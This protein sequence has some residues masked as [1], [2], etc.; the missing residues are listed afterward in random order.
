MAARFEEGAFT[1]RECGGCPALVA[2]GVNCTAAGAAE[3]SRCKGPPQLIQS[4]GRIRGFSVREGFSAYPLGYRHGVCGGAILMF[5]RGPKVVTCWDRFVLLLPSYPVPQGVARLGR[6]PCALSL[7]HRSRRCALP[8]PS[9]APVP[10][11]HPAVQRTAAPWTT[12]CGAVA[13]AQRGSARWRV[14][15]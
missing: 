12:S 4:A 7:H 14:T 10:F 9:P 6:E 5:Q 15:R 8:S 2:W 1:A 11:P 3:G 13:A